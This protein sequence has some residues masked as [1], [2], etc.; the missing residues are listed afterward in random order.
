MFSE[1]TLCDLLV[2]YPSLIEAAP[3]NTCLNKTF[4]MCLY[5]KRIANFTLQSGIFFWHHRFNLLLQRFPILYHFQEVLFIPVDAIFL[6]WE[7]GAIH[8][9]LHISP[10]VFSWNW[11][12]S[13][14]ICMLFDT[15]MNYRTIF[16]TL[17]LCNIKDEVT[18]K[19]IYMLNLYLY[20]LI[21]LLLI[22]LYC[23]RTEWM[24]S[25]VWM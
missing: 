5:T 4:K 20:H 10:I 1:V 19:S 16:E 9:F 23:Y 17:W 13:I 25:N 18:F 7:V 15:W 21:C 11:Q 6:P 22:L 8:C 14:I 3:G 12:N 24:V 2:S